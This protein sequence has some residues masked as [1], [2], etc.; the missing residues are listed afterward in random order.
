MTRRSEKVLLNIR[1]LADFNRL[2]LGEASFNALFVK[3][4]RV[5]KLRG[6]SFDLSK[7]EFRKL[8]KGLC[9]YC[10]QEPCQV[11][12]RSTH[13]G[14]YTYNGIDRLDNDLGYF[15]ANCVACC[16]ICNS[17]KSNI[18]AS[19]F[20]DRIAKISRNMKLLGS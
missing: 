2:P 10:G 14:T 4:K 18:S 15:S 13:N 3:Y 11:F 9:Y 12:Y 5:A 17:M 20:I 6:Y 1:K 16:K 19:D 7:E 8:S